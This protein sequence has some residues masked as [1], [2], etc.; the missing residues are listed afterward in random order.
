MQRNKQE[1][2]IQ[3]ASKLKVGIVVSKY[4]FDEITGPLLEGAHAVL[5]EW[6]VAPK[7]I[8]VVPVSGSWE[9]PYG[10]V[11]LLKK[12]KVDAIVTLGCIIKGETS[13]D[14]HIA[15]AVTEG[16]MR[17]SLER[18]IPISLGVITANTF[19]QAKARSSGNNN[20]GKEAA[21]AVL[22]SGLLKP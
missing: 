21:V 16:L 6:K 11:A 22:E 1:E 8:T 17:L 13:H 9:I 15:A 20:K 4:Y 7:N 12:K 5:S 3:N 2:K 18:K 10:C 14:H 19:E